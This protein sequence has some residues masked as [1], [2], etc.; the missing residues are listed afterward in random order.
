MTKENGSGAQPF[1]EYSET[2]N[3]AKVL[4]AFAVE[5]VWQQLFNEHTHRLAQRVGALSKAGRVQ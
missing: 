5:R 2:A 3:A 4:M 1:F